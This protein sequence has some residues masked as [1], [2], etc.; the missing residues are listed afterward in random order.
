[1]LGCHRRHCYER[2]HCWHYD[3]RCHSRRGDSRMEILYAAVTRALGTE[4][5]DELS[6]HGGPQWATAGT[7]VSKVSVTDNLRD[8]SPS[9]C[10]PSL[11]ISALPSVGSLPLGPM[12]GSSDRCSSLRRS[13]VHKHQQQRATAC[14]NVRPSGHGRRHV[15]EMAL[16]SKSSMAESVP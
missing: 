6:C 14:N 9:V 11:G 1:M 10:S 2:C 7:L 4:T 13:G 8:G 3:R 12:P 15:K 5:I 16:R